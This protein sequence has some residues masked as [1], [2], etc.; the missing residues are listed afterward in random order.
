[1]A[2]ESRYRHLDEDSPLEPK[3]TPPLAL[4][5]ILLLAGGLWVMSRK[6]GH[7]DPAV[8]GLAVLC[9]LL[10]VRIG[11]FGFFSFSGGAFLVSALLAPGV[12]SLALLGVLLVRTLVR[13]APSA[14]QRALECLADALPLMMLVLLCA[15]SQGMES[16]IARLA[17][18]ALGFFLV[19]WFTPGI[20]Q[21]ALDPGIFLHWSRCRNQLLMACAAQ[22]SCGLWIYSRPNHWWLVLP[23]LLSLADSAR[24]VSM[25]VKAMLDEGLR[26]KAQAQLSA[27]RRELTRSKATQD[28]EGGKLEVQMDSYRLIER[29]LSSLRS[30]PSLKSVALAVLEQV[31][32]RVPSNSV[33]LFLESGGSLKIVAS[34]TPN[35]DRVES[36]PIMGFRETLV[37]RAWQ[38]GRIESMDLEERRD[39]QRIFTSDVSAVAAPISNRGVIYVGS[40]QEYQLSDQELQYL[41]SLARHSWLALQAAQSQEEQQV[42]YQGELLARQVSEKLL[43]RLA[44]LVAG[45][46]QLL[47][48]SEPD[49]LVTAGAELMQRLLRSQDTWTHFKGN[50]K[51]FLQGPLDGIR[52]LA[53][54]SL[55]ARRPILH[56]EVQT[57]PFFRPGSPYKSVLVVPLTVHQEESG[58]LL[59]AREEAYE[60][61]DQDI[62]TLMALQFG[63]ILETVRLYFDLQVAHERLAE[64]QAQ[65][66]QSS[67][68]AAIGQLAGGVAHELN[69]PLGAVTVSLDAIALSIDSRPEKAK[70][71]LEKT[72]KACAKM[73][74]IIAKLLFYSR[75]SANRREQSD[76]NSVVRDTLDFIGSQIRLENVEIDSQSQTV[77]AVFINQNEIQQI[78]VNLLNNAKDA[79]LSE[80]TA[81]K[82][83][84]IRTFQEGTDCCVQVRDFGPGI[85]EDKRQRIF[86]PFFTTKPVGQGTGLGLSVSLQLAEQNGGSLA[87]LMH[88]G[89]GA[90]F[91]LRLPQMD[92][93]ETD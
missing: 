26:D 68:M 46:N 92:G 20:F 2:I 47:P 71:R 37:E 1:M 41:D 49:Q 78:L 29:M 6:G 80:P 8:L 33:A 62:L 54:S 79:V 34:I 56:N 64:S 21:A 24:R 40:Q 14:A 66:V 10:A 45:M 48:L 19:W 59:A 50:E 87:L 75:D 42:A 35:Q 72:R 76:V 36:V 69:T 30:S 17:S 38:R 93:S 73:K 15:F 55:K 13:P 88:S 23:V 11:V 67:K 77:P 86:D 57:S 60:R 74:S 82:R 91:Q 39:P 83:I 18:C 7:P 65:L 43:N 16:V 89:P 22:I 31:R 70:E 12:T 61:E 32:T 9:E 28:T 90:L 4:V 51:N 27:S 58:F 84:E 25:Q 81:Q 53:Q 85:P 63:P 3:V 44:D 5:G 52:E